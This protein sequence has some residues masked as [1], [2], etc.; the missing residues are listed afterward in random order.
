MRKFSI[1][2]TESRSFN[3]ILWVWELLN[4]NVGGSMKLYCSR[5]GEAETLP[6]TSGERALST[7]GRIDVKA[8]ANYLAARNVRVSRVIHSG[9]YR[10]QQTAEILHHSIGG[11]QPLEVSQLLLPDQFAQP[12][13]K[14]VNIWKQDTLLVSHLPFISSFVNQLITGNDSLEIVRF[15]PGTVVCLGCYGT[16]DHWMVNWVMPVELLPPHSQ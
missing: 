11:S 15:T 8:M 9:K 10:A 3:G 12:L 2:R 7:Q 16:K 14:L 4:Q 13:L 5:H 6:N 1:V